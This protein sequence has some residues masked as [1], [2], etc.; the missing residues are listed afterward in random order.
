LRRTKSPADPIDRITGIALH[1]HYAI[2]SARK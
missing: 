2:L 1:Y